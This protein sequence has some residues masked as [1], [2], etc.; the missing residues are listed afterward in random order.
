M[1]M[2]LNYVIVYTSDMPRSIAFYR[3]TLGFPVKMESSGWTEFHT[4]ATTLAL[5]HAKPA[6]PPRVAHGDTKAG[7]AHLGLEVLDI[8]KFYEEK[9]AKGV[10]FTMPPTLREFGRKLAIF[11]DP[12]GLPISV[13]EEVR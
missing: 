4:G 8:E 12:D 9:K 11:V 5:H 7:E 1:L 6:N 13:T 2:R 10:D 3:D